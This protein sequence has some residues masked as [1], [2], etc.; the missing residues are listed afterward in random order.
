[1]E[2]LVASKWKKT[3]KVLVSRER[4][5]ERAR[6]KKRTVIEKAQQ[7]TTTYIH[8]DTAKCSATPQM[9]SPV[10]ERPSFSL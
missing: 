2:E 3:E 4:A 1:V 6:A 10:A 8:V 5:S 9:S 7:K